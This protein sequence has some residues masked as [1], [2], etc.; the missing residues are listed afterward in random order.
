MTH[1]DFPGDPVV[2]SPL[3]ST[4]NK[5]LNPGLENKIQQVAG[6]LSPCAKTTEARVPMTQQEKPQHWET[7]TPQLENS[8]HSLQLEKAH[9]PQQRAS[10]TAMKIQHSQ[11]KII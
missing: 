8:L 5:G 9:V 1:W 2:G 3:A 11:N 10:C 7:R 4:G 6:Q